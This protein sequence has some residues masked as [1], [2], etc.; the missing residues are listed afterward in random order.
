MTCAG[1][2]GTSRSV[3]AR[4]RSA[5]GPPASCVATSSASS[6]ALGTL[7]LVGTMTAMYTHRLAMARDRAQRESAKAVKVSGML[8]G[9]LSSADP[10][11]NSSAGDQAESRGNCSIPAPIRCSANWPANPNCRPS[12]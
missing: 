4:T 5:T 2:C 8:M 6:L 11:S 1:T 9:A 3:R 10:Y 7:L 12:C